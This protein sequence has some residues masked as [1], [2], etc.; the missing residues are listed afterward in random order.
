MLQ[1]MAGG[2]QIMPMGHPSAVVPMAVE[3]PMVASAQPMS[4]P[5]AAAVLVVNDPVEKLAK[6][7]EMLDR[8]LLSE[9]E[10]NAK[11]AEVLATM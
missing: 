9:S 8:G 10:Y 3:Q 7:K 11:K 5:M 4:V 6:L 1:P 2:V